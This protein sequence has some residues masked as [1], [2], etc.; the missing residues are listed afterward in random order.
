MVKR[1]KSEYFTR[2]ICINGSV[3]GKGCQ[4]THTELFQ[5]LEISITGKIHY[6]NF[7]TCL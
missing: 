3:K 6:L 5:K 4:N 1:I 2:L 7:G